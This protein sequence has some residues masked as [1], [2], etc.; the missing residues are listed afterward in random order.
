MEPL[1]V[2]KIQQLNFWDKY[3]KSVLAFVYGVVTVV[4]PLRSGDHHIDPSE[5]IVIAL[6]ATNGLLVY[7][8]PLTPRFKSIKS[9]VNALM[10]ALTVA[11]TVIIGGIDMNDWFLIGAAF[12]AAVGVKL[13]PAASLRD[14][15]PVVVGFGT[16]K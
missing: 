7:I 16:D 5:G 8:V 14:V 9:V 6:A 13:A 1:S 4:I 15:S 2:Q 3:G 11:S 10:A 12:L